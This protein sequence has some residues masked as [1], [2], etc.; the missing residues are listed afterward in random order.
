DHAGEPEQ[1]PRARDQRG[2]DDGPLAA[3][4]HERPRQEPDALEEEDDARQQRDRGNDAHA[5][6]HDYPASTMERALCTADTS[7]RNTISR[8]MYPDIALLIL[9][10]V[11]GGVVI[12][13]GLLKFGVVGKGGSLAGVGGWF[14]SIGLRPGLFWAYVAALA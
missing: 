3:P 2:A 1:R 13:H 8:S 14:D 4:G 10:V 9:R 6:P 5:E 12:P 7:A 11:I